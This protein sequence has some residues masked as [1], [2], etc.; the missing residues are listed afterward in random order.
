MSGGCEWDYGAS[1][2]KV[3][4]WSA[5]NGVGYDPSLCS[6][7]TTEDGCWQASPFSVG[8][9]CRGH[10]NDCN[11]DEYSCVDTTACFTVTDSQACEQERG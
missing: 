7:A 9:M 10:D 2:C 6:A 1:V 3:K 8:G 11:D 5:T 4:S